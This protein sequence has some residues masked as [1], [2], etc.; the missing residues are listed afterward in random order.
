MRYP[1]LSGEGRRKRCRR[2]VD[3]MLDDLPLD[4]DFIIVADDWRGWSQKQWNNY[5]R[6]IRFLM[7]SPDIRNDEKLSAWDE[8]DWNDHIKGRFGVD[9]K[10]GLTRKEF[11]ELLTRIQPW[12]VHHFGVDIP[13]PDPPEE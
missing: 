9:S 3:A 8:G 7:A 4:R 13:D 1:L 6:M 10:L 12:A 11:S 5:Y 2:I